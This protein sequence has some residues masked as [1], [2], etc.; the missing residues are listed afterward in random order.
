MIGKKY[1]PDLAYK[2]EAI[3]KPTNINKLIQKGRY[4]IKVTD[5]AG[6]IAEYIIKLVK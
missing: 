1:N 3:K 5:L 2:G 4:F 6:N